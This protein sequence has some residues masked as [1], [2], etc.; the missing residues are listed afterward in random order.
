MLATPA[1][2]GPAAH[3]PNHETVPAHEAERDAYNAA[4]SELELGWRWDART[5][6]ELLHI[7]DEKSRIR[8]YIERYHAHLLRAYD[9]AFL[10]DLIYETK[11]RCQ[12]EM[13]RPPRS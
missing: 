3:A 7:P 8:S 13:S 10:S 4:F 1:Q 9:V 2:H 5:Y 6:R 11:R 12:Q